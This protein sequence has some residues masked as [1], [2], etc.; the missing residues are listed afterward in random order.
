MNRI[1][2]HFI[3]NHRNHTFLLFWSSTIPNH[4]YHSSIFS[5]SA[6]FP[7]IFPFYRL[8]SLF[9][10]SLQTLSISNLM[11]TVEL[12]LSS[13]IY[14]IH[15]IIIAILLTTSPSSLIS[16]L[17]ITTLIGKEALLMIASSLCSSLSLL[18]LSN[19]IFHCYV[20]VNIFVDYCTYF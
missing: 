4:S 18:H 2:Y 9:L 10:P 5:N 15:S 3:N 1:W 19:L 13:A 14:Y 16:I 17:L 12:V 8:L 20:V 7:S 11:G 6:L